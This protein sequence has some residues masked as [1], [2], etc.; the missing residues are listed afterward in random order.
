MSWAS[1]CMDDAFLLKLRLCMWL[2]TCVYII[3]HIHVYN[4]M[5]VITYLYTYIYSINTVS[6]YCVIIHI[7][8]CMHIILHIY[9][10]MCTVCS[11]HIHMIYVPQRMDCCWSDPHVLLMSSTLGHMFWN[12]VIGGLEHEWIMIFHSVGNFIIP[13]DFHWWIFQGGRYTTS[14]VMFP[15]SGLLHPIVRK[16]SSPSIS[17]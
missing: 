9:I 16:A 14:R 15:S 1:S 2:C 12:W 13:T 10:Y 5:Y 8:I 7:C 3:L 6:H 4:A 11:M 17:H